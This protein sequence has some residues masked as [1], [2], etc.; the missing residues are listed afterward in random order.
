MT[1]TLEQRTAKIYKYANARCDCGGPAMGTAHA[2]DCAIE[3]A[4][5]N[6][7]EE[8]ADQLFQEEGPDE[9]ADDRAACGGCG[10]RVDD[11]TF[12]DNHG[13]CSG[14]ANFR[15][16]DDEYQDHIEAN[17]GRGWGRDSREP[18]GE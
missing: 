17:G 9:T 6:A 15:P 18:H 13:L 4:W 5:D 8:A 14:C 3:L 1:D 11:A 12:D 2:P 10:A 16:E 7:K